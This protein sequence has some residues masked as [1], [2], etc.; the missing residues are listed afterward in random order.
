M[1]TYTPTPEKLVEYSKLH[2]AA[3]EKV[4][5]IENAADWQL[6]KEDKDITF[7]KR[8]E[9]SSS[10]AQVKSVVTIPNATLQ[11]VENALGPVPV[12]DEK[13]PDNQRHGLDIS[14]EIA[15]SGSDYDIMYIATT[16]PGPMISGR[17]FIYYRKKVMKD[18][19]LIYINVSIPDNDVVPENPKYVRA[20]TNF[21]GYIAQPVADKPSD[22]KLEFFVH[23]DPKGK[24]PSW[25]YNKFVTSQ[26]YAAKGIRSKILKSKQ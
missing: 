2:D 15:G 13:T 1:A 22:I 10:F 26:G 5:S 11:D 3:V 24:V 18:G 25:A 17:D 16:S 4:L 19:K 9:P 21:Q 12:V 7:Y 8:F 20:V 23:A 14:R 6:E